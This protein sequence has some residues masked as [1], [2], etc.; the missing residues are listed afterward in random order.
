MTRSG[1]GR[2]PLDTLHSTTITG[3]LDVFSGLNQVR[4]NQL[5]G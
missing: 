2:H 5:D 1:L 4:S 3:P